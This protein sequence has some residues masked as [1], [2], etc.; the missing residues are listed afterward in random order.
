MPPHPSQ[1][2]AGGGSFVGEAA[3]EGGR[4]GSL[5]GVHLGREAEIP[6]STPP[7]QPGQ[8]HQSI[9]QHMLR[10]GISVILQGALDRLLWLIRPPLVQQ[11]DRRVGHAERDPCRKVPEIHR[12]RILHPH[13]P[14]PLQRPGHT[15]AL[16]PPESA[17]HLTPL[18]VQANS[19]ACP[20][21]T[22]A[23]YQFARHSSSV[24]ARAEGGLQSAA[25]PPLSRCYIRLRAPTIL[26]AS[27]TA[28]EAF[29][30]YPSAPNTS[31]ISPVTGAPPIMI[32]T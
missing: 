32:L 2:G 30:E 27:L 11:A 31:A 21:S 17:Q 6:V 7:H 24:M 4:E 25:R 12:Q 15:G 23:A 29:S 20:A 1:P 13:Q 3:S 19:S 26:I 14:R 16:L 10:V 8:P 28:L 5:H 22:L 9:L 18:R